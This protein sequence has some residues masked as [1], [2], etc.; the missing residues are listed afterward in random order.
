MSSSSVAAKIETRFPQPRPIGF[1][2][3]TTRRPSLTQTMKSFREWYS[4]PQDDQGG[5]PTLLQAGR[6]KLGLRHP[7]TPRRPRHWYHQPHYDLKMVGNYANLAIKDQ[8]DK[9]VCC[10]D[11]SQSVLDDYHHH[12]QFF[13]FI[14]FLFNFV[15]QF[16]TNVW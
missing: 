4:L 16:N 9:H 10:S 8:N 6:W 2:S 3:S 7:G 14:I 11:K 5:E 1:A 15:L 13:I 12:H